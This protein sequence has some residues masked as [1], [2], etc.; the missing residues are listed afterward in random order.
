MGGYH[1]N[2]VLLRLD[3]KTGEVKLSASDVVICTV[4][5]GQLAELHVTVDFAAATVTA[6][7]SDLNVI[8]TASLGQPPKAKEGYTQAQTWLEWQSLAANYLFYGYQSR[9]GNV[10]TGTVTAITL[11]NLAIFD[12]RVFEAPGARS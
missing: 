11:D 5:D 6:Y 1:G 10:S 2:Y 9:P 8:V 4:A 7:D 12:G 3:A